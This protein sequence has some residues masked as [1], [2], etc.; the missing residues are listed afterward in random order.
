MTWLKTAQAVVAEKQAMKVEGQL[1]DL[2]TAGMLLAVYNALNETNAAKLAALELP[3]A[4]EVG[5]TVLKKTEA[6]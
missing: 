4:V 1:L 5:W 6:I 3:I 2:T